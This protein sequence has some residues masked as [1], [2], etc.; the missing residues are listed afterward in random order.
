MRCIRCRSAVAHARQQLA[1][2][3]RLVDVVVGAEIERLDLFGFA[4]ARRQDDDRHIGPFARP[5]DD[6]LAVAIRQAKIEQHDVGRLGGNAF[7]AFG[8]RAG[9]CHLVVVGFERGLEKAQDRRLV[10]DDQNANLGAHAAALFARKCHD[11][12]R[13]APA[14]RPGFRR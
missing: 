11:E 1:D 4:L 3:E 6:V 12:A 7:D 2:I 8:N 9:A 14:F 13:A 5:P 10:V